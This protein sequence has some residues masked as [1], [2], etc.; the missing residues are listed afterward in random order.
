MR[1]T[2]GRVV[3][4]HTENIRCVLWG[5]VRLTPPGLNRI[6]HCLL[7]KGHSRYVHVLDRRPADQPSEPTTLYVPGTCM[8][9]V[10]CVMMHFVFVL[11]F[12]GLCMTCKVAGV[13]HGCS[14][15]PSIGQ[16]GRWILLGPKPSWNEWTNIWVETIMSTGVCTLRSCLQKKQN[17]FIT[18]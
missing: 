10:P 11:S 13:T 7:G 6:T 3:A 16:W 9:G 14:L 17:V 12:I 1:P 15:E 8:Y 4:C 2:P 18:T 5:A